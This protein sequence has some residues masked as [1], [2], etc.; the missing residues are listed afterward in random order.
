MNQKAVIEVTPEMIE[1]G[2]RELFW[3]DENGSW[4]SSE[5]IVSRIFRAMLSARESDAAPPSGS[6]SIPQ[7]DAA[8]A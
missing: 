1:A 6:S 3:Y 4:A 2:Q 8:V 7:S 5:E